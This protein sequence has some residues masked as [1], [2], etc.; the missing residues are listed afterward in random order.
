VL[1]LWLSSFL[2]NI[3]PFIFLAGFC[4]L[5]A[6]LL[7]YDR[8]VDAPVDLELSTFAAIVMTLT[9]GLKW[10]IIS[11]V[12]TKTAAIINN[13]DFN[14]SSLLAMSAYVLAAVVT[15]IMPEM[16]I[17]LLGLIVVMIVN[18]YSFIMF[19]YLLMLSYFEVGM[20]NVTN[21]IFNIV[22]LVGFS[23]VLIRVLNVLAVV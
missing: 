9:F 4:V 20:Y 21:I 12:L 22:L 7:I 8:Y 15:S 17:I 14:K 18:L 13:R 16:N 2:F 3:W 6:L 11:A 1:L 10:G 5:N 23:E 19:K